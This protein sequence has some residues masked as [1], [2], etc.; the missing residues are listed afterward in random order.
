MKLLLKLLKHR[1]VRSAL[2]WPLVMSVILLVLVAWI[3]LVP[4]QRETRLIAPFALDSGHAFMT[5]MPGIP[6]PQV[7]KVD[8]DYEGNETISSLQVLEDGKPLGPPHAT[9]EDIRRKGEGRFS[10]LN[11][12]VYFSAKDNSDPNTSGKTYALKYTIVFR[13]RA[14]AGIVVLAVLS[15]VAIM[16]PQIETRFFRKG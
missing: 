6:L 3:E 5:G 7:F 16:A 4:W 10:H 12:T 13:I 2:E 9:R 14:I 11:T 8:Y 15:F 1:L